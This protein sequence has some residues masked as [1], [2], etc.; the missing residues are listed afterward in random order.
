[1]SLL[2]A[3]DVAVARTN[4]TGTIGQV[5]VLVALETLVE[6]ERVELLAAS[7]EGRGTADYGKKADDL[8]MKHS[9]LNFKF[10]K[11]KRL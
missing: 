3:G 2:A 7:Q 5:I 10:D 9:S 1:M 11:G 4:H 6:V 8:S